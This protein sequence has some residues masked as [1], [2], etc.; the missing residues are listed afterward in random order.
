M[1]GRQASGMKSESGIG[2]LE[3]KGPLSK[4]KRRILKF[5]SQAMKNEDV[6]PR[7][8]VVRLRGRNM[9]RI[10]TGRRH[11]NL[12]VPLGMNLAMV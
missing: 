7:W 8:I 9:K 11:K 10:E 4:A 5:A 1:I 12:M 2:G 3:N 6:A